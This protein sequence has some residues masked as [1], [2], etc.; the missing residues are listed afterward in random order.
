MTDTLAAGAEIS[1]AGTQQT[2]EGV[3]TNGT[4]AEGDT[5][6]QAGAPTEG[7]GTEAK[8]DAQALIELQLP[9]GMSVD[10]GLLD[11]FKAVAS[12]AK[13]TAAERAQKSL[14]LAVKHQQAMVDAHHAR[15]NE[16]AESVKTDKELGGEKL[17]ETLATA[18]K[19]IDLGPPELK[20]LL[21]SSGL[22]NHPAV[23]KWAYTVGKAL[24]EDRFVRGQAPQAQGSRESR[25][26]PSS[27]AKA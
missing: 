25:L 12:D 1:E 11:E 10:Q 18:R 26:Y 16:W 17:P 4:G 21:N 24:S 9:E 5:T 2:A 14:D 13:L 7:P 6:A 3:S 8:T 22:G 23:V 20:E 27:V 19:A 15:V